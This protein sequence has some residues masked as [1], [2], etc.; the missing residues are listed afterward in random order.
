MSNINLA[1]QPQKTARCS[2]FRIKEI[3]GLY[4]LCVLSIAKTKALMSCKITVQLICAFAFAYAKSRFSHDAAQT[5]EVSRLSQLSYSVKS[6]WESLKTL[7][8]SDEFL[9]FSDEFLH[10][11]I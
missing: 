3:E 4:Y 7:P 11:V 1:V 9:R 6:S 10:E 8:I 2:K 5:I